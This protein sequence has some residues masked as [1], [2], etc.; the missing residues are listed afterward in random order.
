MVK[1]ISRQPLGTQ[2]VFDIGVVKDHNFLT[3]SG[4]IASNCFNK[5]H[6]AAYAYVTYQTAYLKAHFP[7]EYMAALLT[8]NSGQQDKVQRYIA[9]AI[10]MGIEVEPPDI[11]RSTLDFTPI[12]TNILFGLSA[13]RNLGEGAIEN[14]IKSRTEDGPF[15][16]LADICDRLDSRAVN[17]R[18]LEAL[19]HSGAC[20]ALDPQANRRQ[21]AEDL[22]LVMDWAQSRAKDRASGQG[23]L[24]DLFGDGND[25][26]ES[27]S[28]GG[29]AM[30]PKASAVLDYQPQERLKLEKE[31]L[32]FYVS[33][34]PLKSVQKPSRILAPISLGDADQYIEKGT[35]SA[36][37]LLPEVK[38]VITKK[39]DRMAIVQVED[40]SGTVDAVVFPRSYARIGQHIRMDARLMVWGK[41]DRR[42]DRVQFIID[43]AEPVEDIRMVMVEMAIQQANDIEQQ[44]RLKTLIQQQQSPEE[45]ENKVPVVA[46]INTAG[47]RHFVRLGAQFRVRDPEAAAT[48]LSQANFQARAE[49]L[50]K[51]G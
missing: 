40:L 15:E 19:I 30:A 10:A 34:H 8:V 33:D 3:E 4:F 47:Q 23:N 6:S 29:L 41:I 35:V 22:P 21:M 14:L 44:Y 45:Q 26:A 32:G 27:H 12:G 49:S 11:N 9:N 50:I 13:V 42:D 25:T 48:A 2:A 43:D 36:I 7:V 28:N 38:D 20:D 51:A 46:V 39:G 16:S 1:I 24:F 18:A 31:L 37:V 5:S 17:R